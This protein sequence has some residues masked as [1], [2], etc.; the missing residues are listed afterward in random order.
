MRTIH[1]NPAIPWQRKYYEAF[2]DGGWEGTIILG[3]HH[4]ASSGWMVD[5]AYWGDPDCVSIAWYD[6]KKHFNWGVNKPARYHPETKPWKEGRR[7]L[8]LCDFGDD[9][10]RHALKARPHFDITIRRHPSEVSEGSLDEAIDSHDLCM[11]YKTTALVKAVISGLPVICYGEDS[12]VYPVAG[13]VR[14][15]A[16]PDRDEWL[17]DLSWHNWGFEEIKSGEAWEHFRHYL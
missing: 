10:Q 3:P 13:R 9:G 11:G 8:V 16:K 6:G 7:L 12:P 15:I 5:R 1:V 14:D 17:C 4:K 2:R